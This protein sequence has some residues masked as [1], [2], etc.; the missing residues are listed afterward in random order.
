MKNRTEISCEEV[1]Q[2]L[3]EKNT[4]ELNKRIKQHLEFCQKCREFQELLTDISNSTRI[5]AE[6]NLQP[7]DQILGML[8]KR[9]KAQTASTMHKHTGNFFESLL[10]LFQRRIPVYQALLAVFIAGIFYFSFTKI[11]FFKPQPEEPKLVLQSKKQT[12]QPL[13][14]PFQSQLDQTNQIGKSL[15]EDSLLARFRVSIL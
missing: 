8:K 5:T 4:G 9:F 3:L 6:E 10:A 1:R 14:F 7:D 15:A 12:V 13:E 11:N 2:M